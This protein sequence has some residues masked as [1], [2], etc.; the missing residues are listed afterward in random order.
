MN[1]VP[2]AGV[3][4]WLVPG[5]FWLG[6]PSPRFFPSSLV[7]GP[8]LRGYPSPR[9]GGYTRP[10]QGVPSPGVPPAR[11]GVPLP[12]SGQ[13][14][15]ADP[16]R[17]YPLLRYPQ[18]GLGYP[19]PVRTGLICTSPKT[20]QQSDYLLRGGRYPS[21]V[22]AG[23]SCSNFTLCLNICIINIR[24]NQNHRF[25][26]LWNMGEMYA[27]ILF[28]HGIKVQLYWSE[29]DIAWNGCIV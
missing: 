5:P 25:P 19:F 2:S 13:D 29:S 16:G 21:C 12:K 4:Q 22:H 8:F 26:L 20:K 7:P 14:W 6:Y 10:R 11:T 27:L 24:Q 3:P 23:L 18:P 17:E 28:S 15:Y 1:L 9:W